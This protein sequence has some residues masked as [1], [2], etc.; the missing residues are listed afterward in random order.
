LTGSNAGGGG[1]RVLWTAVR[2]IQKENPEVI[3][4]IY[5]GDVDVTPS[6]ILENVEVYPHG[7]ISDL[8]DDST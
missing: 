8:S 1:E 6:I 5:S 3:S 2:T 7:F 4:V